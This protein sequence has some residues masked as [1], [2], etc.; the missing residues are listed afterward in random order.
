MPTSFLHLTSRTQEGVLV[1]TITEN[2]V[3]GEEVPEA[4]RQEMLAAVAKTNARKVVVDFQQTQYISSAAFRPLLALRRKLQEVGG[5]MLVCGLNPVVGDVFYTTRMIS[6][7]A[8]F[9]A[10]FEMEPDVA[11]AV[12]RLR[13][14]PPRA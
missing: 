10:P 14:D 12:A 4:L 2:S 3:E 7:G 13:D 11:A 1:L 6:T 9:T 8:S 5:R